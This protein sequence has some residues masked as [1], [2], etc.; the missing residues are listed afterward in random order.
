[1]VYQKLIYLAEAEGFLYLAFC[2]KNATK[3]QLSL[4]SPEK[5]FRYLQ[6]W[7]FKK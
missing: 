6:V 5:Y 7:H 3:F 4:S 1:V 2:M